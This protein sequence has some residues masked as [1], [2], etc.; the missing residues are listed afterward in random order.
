M[1]GGA[2]IM[3]PPHEEVHEDTPDETGDTPT[4]TGD[5]PVDTPPASETVPTSSE[6]T[7]N[8]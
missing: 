6:D 7:S 8:V 3:P 5:T 4:D 1:Q 2:V